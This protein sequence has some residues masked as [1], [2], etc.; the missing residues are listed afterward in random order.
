M[1]LFEVTDRIASFEWD[2]AELKALHQA[3]SQE[4]KREVAALVERMGPLPLSA[5]A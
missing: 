5:T 1:R 4:M 3:F 2:N